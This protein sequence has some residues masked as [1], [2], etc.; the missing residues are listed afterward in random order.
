[1]AGTREW[2]EW[3]HRRPEALTDLNGPGREQ[4]NAERWQRL[5]ERHGEGGE[6]ENIRCFSV[7]G[8]AEIGGNHT[9]HNHGRVLAAG[10]TLDTIA[11][12]EAR[13]K[14]EV[15]LESVGFGTYRVPLDDLSPR[16]EERNTTAALIRGVAA[17]MRELGMGIGGFRATVQSEVLPGSGL[18]SSAAFEV[19]VVTIM[20]ALYNGARLTGLERAMIGRYAENVYFGKPCGLM[21]QT[22]CALGGMITIDFADPEQ[23]LVERIPF[24]FAK[25][26]LSLAVVNTGGGHEDLTGEYAAIFEEMGAVAR[27]FGKPALREVPQTDFEAALPALRGQVCDRALLRAAHFF[28]DN[29]RVRRQAE[30]LRA[31][32]R[33]AFLEEVIHSGQSSWMW[34]QNCYVAGSREQGIP[35]ALLE[36]QRIL[37]GR[38]AWRVQGGGF[39]GTIQAFV[40]NGLL[41]EYADRMR[42]IFGPEACQTV[43][44]RPV[45]AVELMLDA[46]RPYREAQ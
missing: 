36:S 24:D 15:V 18:S 25:A 4:R 41:T 27:Y 7:P 9:D 20:D 17:R 29:E 26:G 39:A 31:G 23:P 14:L 28:G 38:G 13:A 1:M 6:A 11:A 45:G 21:D 33:D 32:N 43:S 12:V 30:A 42:Q 37:A 3:L 10:V 19:L 22:A 46:A 8:R 2:I 44:I 35:L 40:P 34:L 16:E 5:L